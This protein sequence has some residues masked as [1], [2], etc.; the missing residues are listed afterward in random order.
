MYQALCQVISAGSVDIQ[1]LKSSEIEINIPLHFKTYVRKF[2][3]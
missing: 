3:K 1:K 2:F